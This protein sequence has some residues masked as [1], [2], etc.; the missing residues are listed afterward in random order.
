MI[1]AAHAA[2]AERTVKSHVTHVFDQL[3]VC[4]RTEAVAVAPRRGLL[5][6]EPPPA[7]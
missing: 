4:S 1:Q 6:D 5:P 7:S 2:S 3:G